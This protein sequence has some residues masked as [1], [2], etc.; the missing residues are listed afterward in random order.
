MKDDKFLLPR[1][2]FLVDLL[3]GSDDAVTWLATNVDAALLVSE[4]SRMELYFGIHARRGLDSITRESSLASVE[5]LLSN[6]RPRPFLDEE[7]RMAGQLI[8]ELR[9][10]GL[11]VGTPDI[12]IA[13]TALVI[14]IQNLLTRDHSDFQRIPGIRVVEY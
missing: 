12:M 7:A 5:Q 6:F 13:A 2:Y 10:E 9:R 4:I 3:R 14:N 11:T 1:H 8:G